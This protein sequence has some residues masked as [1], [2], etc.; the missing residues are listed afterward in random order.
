[1]FRLT[2]RIM[3]TDDGVALVYALSLL[4]ICSVLMAGGASL[5]L[6][7]QEGAIIHQ[8]RSQA[9]SVARAGFRDA[10]LWLRSNPAQPVTE[11]GPGYDDSEAPE[12]GLVKS[13]PI[14]VSDGLWGRYEVLNVRVRDITE[15]KGKAG[16]GVAWEVPVVGYVYRSVDP[17]RAFCEWPNRVVARTSMV[18]EVSRLSLSLPPAA[19]ISYE[20][21]HMV[22]NK[23]AQVSGGEEGSGAAGL[24]YKSGTGDP[25][26]KGDVTGDPPEIGVD[27]L[28]I[29]MSTVFGA[30][31]PELK[32]VVDYVVTHVKDL[33][34]PLPRL[35]LVYVDGNAT[36]T[37]SRPLVG[38]GL[39]VVDGNMTM[40]A[41]SYSDYAGV[42]YVTGKYNGSA[43]GTITGIL[44][45]RGH[46]NIS[47][48]PAVSEVEYDKEVVDAIARCLGQYRETK[49]VHVL[50]RK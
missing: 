25:H 17:A 11:F 3:K 21:K 22:I 2:T 14:S 13:F 27:G 30:D 36:F 32:A 43:P 35:S 44:V 16:T 28:D 4:L 41:N 33:P 10:V 1:M 42:V 26:V 50:S 24:L 6:S 19:I 47:G 39:L 8:S 20:G 7:S 48:G 12:L 18:G 9:E 45:A 37:S 34:S 38:S 5:I 40:A 49:S 31:A 46:V 29:E 15:A 23:K